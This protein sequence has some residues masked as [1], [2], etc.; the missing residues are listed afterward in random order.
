MS[1]DRWSICPKCGK[2]PQEIRAEREQALAEVYGKVPREEWE[3]MREAA[4][5]PIR[6]DEAM[7]TFREDW[8]IYLQ[9]GAVNVSYT[10]YCARCGAHVEFKHEHPVGTRGGS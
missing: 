9:D 1:A 6:E 4:A 7:E 10:G 5:A 2:T 3:E 8:D